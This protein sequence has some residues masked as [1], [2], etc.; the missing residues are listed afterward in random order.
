VFHHS[1]IKIPFFAFFAH[2]SG[3]RCKEA[4][5]NMLIAMGITAAL[6]ILIGVFPEPLYGIL[7]YSVDYVP[8]TTPHVISQLQLLIWSALAFTF[9]KRTGIYP[10]ELR[11]TNLDTDWVY[12]RLMPASVS[13]FVRVGVPIRDAFIGGAKQLV[14]RLIDNIKIY[15]G[16]DGVFART[17]MTGRTVLLVTVFLL[18]Y[19]IL[20]F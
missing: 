15:H 17:W 20:Y 8:Y 4:P 14:T 16:P 19:L 3:I 12:R 1:G 7:P 10:A 11:L 6:C 18:G 2:D 5:T 13:A 9:L